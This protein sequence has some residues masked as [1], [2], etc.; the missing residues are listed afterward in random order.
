[1]SSFISRLV[2]GSGP[3]EGGV[4][5]PDR[6]ATRTEDQRDSPTRKKRFARHGEELLAQLLTISEPSDQSTRQLASVPSIRPH[7]ANQHRVGADHMPDI[8][9]GF[10]VLGPQRAAAGQAGRAL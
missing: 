5:L 2:I 3:D 7:V 10:R 8:A 6:A 4:G 1:M 9:A